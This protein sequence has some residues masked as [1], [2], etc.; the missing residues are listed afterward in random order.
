MLMLNTT[1]KSAEKP[2]FEQRGEVMNAR[3]DFVSWFVPAAD[4]CQ[5]MFVTYRRMVRITSPSVGVNGHARLTFSRMKSRRLSA[6]TS[7]TRFSRMRPM[8]RPFFSAAITTMDFSSI[9][10]VSRSRPGRTMARRS[11]CSTSKLF[12]SYP[13]NYHPIFLS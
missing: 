4:D 10:P 6:E 7:L 5:V 3:H 9:S 11:L 8:A 12:R 1:L 13:T 2:S